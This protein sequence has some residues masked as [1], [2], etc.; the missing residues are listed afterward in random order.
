MICCI[1][2]ATKFE[3]S[4]NFTII[5]YGRQMQAETILKTDNETESWLS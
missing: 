5:Q 2:S 1:D 4:F 3:L